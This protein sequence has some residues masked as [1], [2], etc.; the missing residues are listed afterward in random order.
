MGKDGTA[1]SHVFADDVNTSAAGE[2]RDLTTIDEV[3]LLDT[4]SA[5]SVIEID[6]PR[7]SRDD[8]V[9]DDVADCRINR[10]AQR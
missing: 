5:A 3:V 7:G 4:R 2:D 9:A 10:L 1:Q 6:P 8:I